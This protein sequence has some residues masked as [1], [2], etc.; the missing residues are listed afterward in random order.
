MLLRLESTLSDVSS[1][2]SEASGVLYKLSFTCNVVIS[3]L[4]DASS[5][6]KYTSKASSEFRAQITQLHDILFELSTFIDSNLS[7]APKI[8]KDI[9]NADTNSLGNFISKP[10]NL[11]STVLNKIDNNGTAISPFFTNLAI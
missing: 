1:A 5:M 10:V 3:D 4:D 8:I 11:E 7:N 6:L 9:L 2:L